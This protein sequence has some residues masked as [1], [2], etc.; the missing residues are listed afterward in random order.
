M[1]RNV[2][3]RIEGLLS[4]AMAA[5]GYE[6]LGTKMTLTQAQQWA[7]F[8]RSRA[9]W[10]RIR[11]DVPKPE[12]RALAEAL[13]PVLR[14]FTSPETGHIGFAAYDVIDGL[15][16]DVTVDRL[17]KDIVTSAAMLGPKRVVTAV[18]DWAEGAPGS[19]VRT[20][21]LRGINLPEPLMGSDAGIRFEKLPDRSDNEYYGDVSS[22]LNVSDLLNQPVLRY[23]VSVD[24]MFYMPKADEDPID[25]M[26]RVGNN[27]IVAPALENLD[28]NKLL[29]ALSLVCRGSVQA[30]CEW[31]DYQIEM[32]L[33]RYAGTAGSM[34]RNVSRFDSRWPDSMPLT[35]ERLAHAMT[36][37]KQMDGR[38]DLE[39]AVSR[40][41][42]SAVALDAANR[43]IDLRTVLES[44]YAQNA[45]QELAFRTAL[46]GAMHLA[47]TRI[48]RTTYYSKLRDFYRLASRMVHGVKQA[49]DDDLAKWCYE[50]CRLAILKR[51]DEPRKLDWTALMLGLR[52]GTGDAPQA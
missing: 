20:L 44:L 1:R 38:S 11:P 7:E 16:L 6:V 52:E 13:A 37:V 46:C 42:N 21:V 2:S 47:P 36:V 39:V 10:R 3:E 27:A 18:L 24:P 26:K 25:R 14:S 34:M 30:I 32:L 17:V 35:E 12:V 23:E 15:V 40:W 31:N 50:T 43:I 4:A 19:Y 9:R 5:S 29:D 49:E 48:E 28:L 8:N 41:K 51:L 33:M 22:F 45:N